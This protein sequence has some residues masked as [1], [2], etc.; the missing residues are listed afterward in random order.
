[1][2]AFGSPEHQ[3]T[4][5]WSAEN[6]GATKSPHSAPMTAMFQSFFSS[7]GCDSFG[8]TKSAS[9]ISQLA[10]SYKQLIVDDGCLD[11]KSEPGFNAAAV[12]MGSIA[13]AAKALGLEAADRSYRS[14]FTINYRALFPDQSRNYR[15]DILEA[16]LEQ[17]SVIW[18]NGDKF[19]FS[20]DAMRRAETLKKCWTN[21]G[22]LLA[23][24]SNSSSERAGLRSHL[25]A[26]DS[27]WAAFENKYISELI[28]IEAQP[29]KLILTAIEHE[30]KLK[31]LE[32]RHGRQKV[33]SLPEYM[34][35]QRKLVRSIAHLN[36]VAN[37][38]RK[39][40]DDLTVEILW[41]AMR[42]I[43]RC[44]AAEKNGDSTDL[45][46][47]AR[48]LSGDVVDAFLAM[49]KYLRETSKCLER[50]DPHLCNNVGLVG[51]LVDWE[52][53]WEVG[54]NYVQN[55]MFLNG[56]CDLVAEIRLAQR[57]TP[58]LKSMCEDCDVELF[59]VLPRILW[60]RG[61]A[62]PAAH[63]HV[64][65]SLLPHRF[66]VIQESGNASE[67]WPCDSELQALI[68]QFRSVYA[69]LM[70][71]WRSAGRDSDRS[72]WEVLIKRVV[73]GVEGAARE[74]T[75]GS[76]SPSVRSQAEHAVES[77]MNKMEGWSMEIQRHNAE[78]WN[79]FMSIIIQ[80]LSGSS[81]GAKET[82]FQV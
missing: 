74:D 18:V 24:W 16:S 17:N 33:I 63:L 44:E 55:E 3:R 82:S 59:M 80:C 7:A 40:R 56:I 65:R 27:A 58:G 39:G 32:T 71:N 72:A 42:T 23:S 1:M 11:T 43:Q 77:F 70:S 20:S 21:L 9:A 67:Q 64:F 81:K 49:R 73:L 51:R 38:R 31:D 60:L 68:E 29:R 35:T 14:N 8:A 34:D 22:V 12:F 47:A 13:E 4:C 75:Y 48:S 30:Q 28:D 25:L 52:E 50:V 78:D 36:S 2:F 53:C 26:L 54:R 6:R 15:V 37:F 5:L 46:S 61:L 79:Q 41:D 45:L 69:L 19:E 76:L 57:I 10:S 66:T 62:K